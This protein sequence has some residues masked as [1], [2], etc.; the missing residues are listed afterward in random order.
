MAWLLA[1]FT[2]CCALPAAA[3]ITVVARYTLINGDTLTRPSYYS[4]RRIRL[5]APDGREFVYDSKL[6]KLTLINHR[7]KTYWTGSLAHADSIA[8]RILSDA[9]KEVAK[10]IEQDQEAWA[11]KV[12]SFNDSLKVVPTG[13]ERRIGGYPTN[14]WILTA[15]SYMQHERWV[16]RGLEMPDFGPDLEK[17]VLASILDPVGRLLM[18]QLIA[19]RGAEG[20]PLA[21]TTKFQ[22]PSQSGSFGFEAI[23]VAGKTIPATA[24]EPP[25]EYKK[26][27]L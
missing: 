20:L 18:R 26:L 6:D 3:D 14:Q 7:N 27:E 13:E 19:L 24:W 21:S 8:D 4:A 22:T 11:R 1:S 25:K 5:T 15:G 17:V 10:V 9:R 23:Q 12:Q 16:A 2:V